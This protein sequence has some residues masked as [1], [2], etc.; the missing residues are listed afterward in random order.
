MNPL[1]VELI[2]HIESLNLKEKALEVLTEIKIDISK[3]GGKIDGYAVEEMIFN[4]NRH[5]LRFLNRFNSTTIL[6]KFD[7]HLKE[8]DINSIIGYYDY[9]VDFQGNFQDDY[10]V[11]KK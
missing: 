11:I 10:F 3:D 7:I 5:E 8:I 2:K 9:E 1:E 4:F 6:A